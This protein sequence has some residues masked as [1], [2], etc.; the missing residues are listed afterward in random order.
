MRYVLIA[1]R[2]KKRKEQRF[3][4]NFDREYYT[5]MKSGIGS[6]YH[7]SEKYRKISPSKAIRLMKGKKDLR[8]L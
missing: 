3:G 2:Y 4:K 7:I 6:K 5:L 8:N 1:L